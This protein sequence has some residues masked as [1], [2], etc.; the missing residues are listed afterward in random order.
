MEVCENV[1]E[2]IARELKNNVLPRSQ[3]KVRTDP[4]ANI[5]SKLDFYHNYGVELATDEIAKEMHQHGVRKI[6]KE[7]LLEHFGW[8]EIDKVEKLINTALT[9]HSD[10]TLESSKDVVPH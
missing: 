6:L 9:T 5:V 8:K 4:L 7:L 3:K 1:S 10:T 2:E